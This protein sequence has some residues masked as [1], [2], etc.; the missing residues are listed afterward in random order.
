[1]HFVTAGDCL[2]TGDANLQDLASGGEV[3]HAPAPPTALLRSYVVYFWG[4]PAPSIVLMNAD[5]ACADADCAA[6]AALTL[7]EGRGGLHSPVIAASC[8]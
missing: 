7:T 3:G 4:A 6:V 8:L 5:C 1:M 2:G